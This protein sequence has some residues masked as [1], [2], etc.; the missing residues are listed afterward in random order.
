MEIPGVESKHGGGEGKTFEIISSVTIAVLATVLAIVHFGAGRYGEKE[1]IAH[2]E[3]SDAYMWYQTK[4]IKGHL[5]ESEKDLLATLLDSGVVRAES[6]KAMRDRVAKLGADAQRYAK[7]K[8]EIEL[9]SAAVGQEN[10][11]EEVDG[12][13]GHV[14]GAKQWEARIEAFDHVSIIFNIGIVLLEISLVV[15]AISLILRNERTKWTFYGIMVLLGVAG[16]LTGAAALYG[17][18]HIV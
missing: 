16:A 7:Q 9:G 14:T 2:N 1:I 4:S 6:E 12:K 13:L 10:W 3:K 8:N 15:G 5:I 18:L 17:A 11:A